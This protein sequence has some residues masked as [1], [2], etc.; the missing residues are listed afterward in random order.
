AR[1]DQRLLV[2]LAAADGVCPEAIE[3][4]ALPAAL[5]EL[6]LGDVVERAAPRKAGAD[7]E[8]G[9]EAA[10]VGR[11]DQRAAGPAALA[12][13]ARQAHGDEKAGLEDRARDHVERA[14]HAVLPREAV[15]AEDPLLVH[16]RLRKHGGG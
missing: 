10:V 6:D 4:P 13:A 7:H 12:A 8:G 2:G 1:G 16:S 5:E 9:E 3:D 14:V 11:D 15:V